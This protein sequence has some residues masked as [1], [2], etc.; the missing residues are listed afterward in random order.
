MVGS[1]K[2]G[3]EVYGVGGE[4]RGTRCLLVRGAKNGTVTA[5]KETQGITFETNRSLPTLVK[6]WLH[7]IPC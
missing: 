5:K 7:S 1:S 4:L 3:L 2:A 6:T